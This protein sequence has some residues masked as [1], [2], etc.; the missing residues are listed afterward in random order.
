MVGN[1]R[2]TISSTRYD[3]ARENQ[4]KQEAGAD[5]LYE[6][7]VGV[8]REGKKLNK[9]GASAGGR[10]SFQKCGI[11]DGSPVPGREHWSVEHTEGEYPITSKYDR[12]GWKKRGDYEQPNKRSETDL[13]ITSGS[14]GAR[15]RVSRKSE[16]KLSNPMEWRKKK[17]SKTRSKKRDQFGL[18][19]TTNTG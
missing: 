14:L 4:K 7:N 10:G 6:A 9:S 8:G 12:R 13:T 15:L 2:G 1:V 16:G 3:F 18:K 5:G 11:Q 17:R 19:A